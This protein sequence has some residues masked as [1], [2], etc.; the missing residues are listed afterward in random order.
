MSSSLFLSSL[1]LPF[2]L[3]VC[4]LV[5]LFGCPTKSTAGALTQTAYSPQCLFSLRQVYYNGNVH[6]SVCDHAKMNGNAACQNPV[7]PV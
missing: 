3:F 5:V 6:Y 2:G 4:P 1:V 7:C